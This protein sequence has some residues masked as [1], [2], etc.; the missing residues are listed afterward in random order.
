MKLYPLQHLIRLAYKSSLFQALAQS[1][2]HKNSSSPALQYA[3]EHMRKH[4]PKWKWTAAATTVF[5]FVQAA[6]SDGRTF[7]AVSN[8]FD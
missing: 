5:V 7:K 2:E 6:N 4:T 8:P 3:D 1:P